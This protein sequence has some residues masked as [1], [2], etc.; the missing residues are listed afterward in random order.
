MVFA[1]MNYTALL[2]ISRFALM[3]CPHAL[4]NCGQRASETGFYTFIPGTCHPGATSRPPERGSNRARRSYA[5]TPGQHRHKNSASSNLRDYGLRNTSTPTQT[6]HHH[7]RPYVPRT[8]AATGP[9]PP[10][11]TWGFLRIFCLNLNGLFG[12]VKNV[13]R[14]GSRRSRLDE[15]INYLILLASQSPDESPHIIAVQET[16]LGMDES[17]PNIPGYCLVPPYRP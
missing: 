1:Y 5:G 8:P 10:A 14:R 2:L 4:Y 7:A 3:T 11:P 12:L 15:I 13:G 16:W 17:A 6:G 9:R